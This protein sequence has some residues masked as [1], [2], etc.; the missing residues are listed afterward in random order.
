METIIKT[1]NLSKYYK[2]TKAVQKLSLTVNKGEIYGFLGVN[3]AGKT[4][5][6]RLLL[7]MINATKGT[8][9]LNE[10]PVSYIKGEGWNQVGYLVEDTNSYPELTVEENLEIIYHLRNLSDKNVI[11]QMINKLK[12]ARYRNVKFKNLSS[13]NKQR[14]GL[15]KALIH[16]PEVLILDEPTKGLDPAGIVEIRKLLKELSQKNN[17][18]IFISSHIL[19]EVSKLVDR[20]GIIDGGKLIQEIDQEDL[21]KIKDKYLLIDTVDN[22][23][24]QSIISEMGYEVFENE[25]YALRIDN[26]Q[27]LNHP[28]K[29][30]VELVN[31]GVPP[32]TIKI[33]QEDLESYFLKLTNNNESGEIQNETT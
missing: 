7:G 19:S 32:K 12:L 1:K 6:I 31:K 29:L 15:A 8:A 27:A 24:A 9:Y 16:N 2:T 21:E 26:I 23:K 11:D 3:G 28:E 33:E 18:T 10:K 20:I 17:T 5:T 22:K 14:L 13:G 25:D 4:T 30:S